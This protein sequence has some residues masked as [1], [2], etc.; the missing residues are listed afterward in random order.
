VA[1]KKQQPATDAAKWRRAGLAGRVAILAAAGRDR[2]LS[3]F[4]CA[5]CRRVWHLLADARSR[6]AVE[7]LERHADGLAPAA[8]LE[9]AAAAARDAE[10]AAL[11]KGATGYNAAFAVCRA[12]AGDAKGA[13]GYAVYAAANDAAGGHKY[14][15]PAW[16]ATYGAA[17][18]AEQQAQRGLL[19][20]LA[21]DPSRPA[22][23]E[24]A[25][26]TPAAVKVAGAVYAEQSFDRLP[27]L[28]DALEEAGCTD[29]ELLAHLHSPGPH[30][31]GCWAVDL[32]LGKE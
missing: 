25:W 3:L 6:D 22:G 19:D 12:L 2:K 32:L 14:G 9:Q 28:A 21:G 4:A 30:V 24:P 10:R 5:C 13:A 16:A 20:E 17:Y 23:A 29:G 18:K 8:E 15:T 1:R 31:R 27:A 26:L 7:A 11:G